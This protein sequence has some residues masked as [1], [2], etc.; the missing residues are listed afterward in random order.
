ME[1]LIELSIW[2]G[3][4]IAATYGVATL[5][6]RRAEAVYPPTGVFVDM[7]G[8]RLHY[9]QAGSGPDVVLLH[10]ASGSVREF[11]FGLMDGLAQRYRVTAFDRPGLGWSD[12]LPMGK[13]GL[14][15]QARLLGRACETLGIVAPVLV[16]QS[17]GGSVAL[18]WALGDR[19]ARALVLIGAPCIPWPGDLDIWYRLNRPAFGRW[20]MPWLAAA[21]IWPGY[22]RAS[23]TGIFAPDPVPAGYGAHIGTGL[24]IRRKTLVANVAQVNG[25]R[26]ALVAMQ[27][28]YPRLTL[29]IESLHGEADKVVPFAVHARAF[30]ALAPGCQLTALPATG[31][32]PHHSHLANVLAAIDRAH[33][34]ANMEQTGAYHGSAL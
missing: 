13:D 3:G 30:A 25:L 21:W 19:P 1:I 27:G 6:R 12:A 9:R 16:G 14:A 20:L 23:L 18:A 29:P 4:L 10:G 11:D 31:H 28:D 2:L 33:S 8:L 22:V 17:Y 7:G 24:T 15:D 5:R 34:R 32:M 26:A